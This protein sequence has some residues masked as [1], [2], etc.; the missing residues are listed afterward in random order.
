MLGEGESNVSNGMEVLGDVLV[1][2]SFEIIGFDNYK[3]PSGCLFG[4]VNE[5]IR[6]IVN[7]EN[8]LIANDRP[9]KSLDLVS[10]G[11]RDNAI[12]WEK[13]NSL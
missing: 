5:C 3:E 2:E 8:V 13:D 1:L 12:G 7:V 4:I 11:F 9:G 6:K 10:S